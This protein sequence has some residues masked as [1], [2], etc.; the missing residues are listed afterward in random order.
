MVG[1]YVG[2][3]H[4]VEQLG[5]GGMAVVYKAY[6]TRL[7]RDVAIKFIRT[8][9][10]GPNYLEQMLKRFEREA[11]SLARMDHLNIVGV[12]DYGEYENSPY[13]V[14]QYLL[15]GTLKHAVDKPMHYADAARLLLPIA[16]ALE[17][18]HGWNVVHRDVKPAN[19]LI[20]E[21]GEPM[22]SDFGIAKILGATGTTQ[23]TGTGMGVGTPQYMAPEQWEGKVV[24]QT[25][26][27]ALGVVLYELVTGRRPYE[28]D[29]PAAVFRMMMTEP[30]PRPKDAAPDLPEEVE[31]M[32]IKALA[33]KPDER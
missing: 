5:Q 2:R 1:Q 15:G 25:D 3:Y 23:L 17:Y 29:T 28:A 30:L 9:E 33:K 14:M 22:L 8:G 11:K 18:A 4:I 7:E 19:I 31:K 26:I 27:Y 10:I 6:D 21:S 13:L 32:L 20:T 12:F 24:T 16:R